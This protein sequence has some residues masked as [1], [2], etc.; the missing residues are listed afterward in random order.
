[1]TKEQLLE[2]TGEILSNEELMMLVESEMGKK[3]FKEIKY[4]IVEYKQT[5][6]YS[7]IYG[8]NITQAIKTLHLLSIDGLL[9]SMEGVRFYDLSPVNK[10]PSV[11]INIIGEY[12]Q[13][14]KSYNFHGEL[15]S[16]IAKLLKE[17]QN[18]K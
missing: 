1:M 11:N 16:E 17:L 2:Q 3:V 18:D 5:S 12:L 14:V 7:E 13:M 4:A 10:L 6:K 9:C 8:V 15:V